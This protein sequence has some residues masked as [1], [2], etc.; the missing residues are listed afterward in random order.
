MMRLRMRAV[1][2]LRSAMA[3]GV[4]PSQSQWASPMRVI[5]LNRTFFTT[6]VASRRPPRPVSITTKSGFTRA[7]RTNATAVRHSKKVTS[8]PFS[9]SNDS[10]TGNTASAA[11]SRSA[12]AAGLPSTK[13]RSASVTRCGDV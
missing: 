11:A 8:S 7:K 3:A 13:K 1:L 6:F 12:P 2:T 9:R 5:T 10:T 4:L